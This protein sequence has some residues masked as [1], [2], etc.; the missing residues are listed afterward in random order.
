MNRIMRYVHLFYHA[1]RQWVSRDMSYFA[2][3]FSYYA[4]LALVPLVL[5]S[6][7]VSGFFYGGD[8]VKNIFLGWGTVLGNDLLALIDIAVQN[9]DIEIQAYSIPLLAVIFFS[10]VSIFAFNVLGSGF[11]RVWGSHR[12]GLRSWLSQSLRSVLFVIIL[13]AYLIL[14]IAAEGF[15]AWFKVRELPFLP[16]FIWFLSISLLFILLFKFLAKPAPSWRGCVFGGF[17]AGL[18][19]IFTNNLVAI[20]LATKPVLS[21]FGA[22]GLLLVLLVW[23]YI[24]ACV[25]FYGAALSH[26]YDRMINNQSSL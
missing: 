24:L 4:P 7:I 13:Q 1:G 20:Y 3:A 19:F 26:M 5:L 15:L 23:V 25:I 18:L 16:E 9:L 12:A 17:S 14:I 8:F 21:I 6:L 11:E 22:A 2:A 10:S